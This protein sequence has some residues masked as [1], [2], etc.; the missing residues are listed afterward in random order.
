MTEPDILDVLS[1]LLET[2]RTFYS[3]AR[4]LSMH[5]EAITIAH[6]RNTASVLAILRNY[7]QGHTRTVMNITLPAN[8]ADPVAVIPTGAQIETATSSVDGIEDTTCSICQE[9]VSAGTRINACR[10]TF[11]TSCISE[12]FS[13]SPRCPMCRADIRETASVSG[14]TQ[15]RESNQRES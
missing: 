7:M 8:W 3:S 13:L 1:S 2:D 9:S 14:Q 11:H 12:W 5:R 15:P 4:F 6:Q 10:H